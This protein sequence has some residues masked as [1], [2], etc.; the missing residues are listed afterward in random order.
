MV[1]MQGKNDV[2]ND[3]CQAMRGRMYKPPSVE[4]GPC[5][6]YTLES[7]MRPCASCNFVRT[8]HSGLSKSIIRA[9]SHFFSSGSVNMVSAMAASTKEC[10]KRIAKKPQS[11]QYITSRHDVTITD[12][13]VSHPLGCSLTPP[14][15]ESVSQQED[16]H[17]AQAHLERRPVLKRRFRG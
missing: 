16:L 12:P 13:N 14:V 15:S 10:T 3:G 8:T 11:T 5:P 17:D 4:S 7:V 9:D 1:P 2:R 6:P